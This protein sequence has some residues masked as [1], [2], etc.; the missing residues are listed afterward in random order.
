[1]AIR[2]PDVTL[3]ADIIGDGP[4]LLLLHGALGDRRTLAP[5]AAQLADRW[6]LVVPTQRHFGP[7]PRSVGIKR[8]GTASQAEDLVVMLD[9]LGLARAHVV[10]WSFS[11]HSTLAAALDA[12]ERI[13]SLFLY[14]PGFPTFVTD[15]AAQA[16]ISADG[17]RA[18]GPVAKAAQRGD[19][20]EAARDLIDAAAGTVGWF[21]AQPPEVRQIHLDNADTIG[22]LFSQ[23]PPVPIAAGDLARLVVPTTLA[24]GADTTAT[25]RLVSQAAAQ[26]IPGA[27]S[28][29]VPAAGHLLPEADPI[30]FARLIAAHLEGAEG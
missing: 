7:A 6:R 19:W 12:P 27:R 29:V 8:F 24:W 11:A 9:A 13:R 30:R 15:A 25:Y 22:L 18:F 26:A 5:V 23:T 1:M 2:L 28:I 3:A 14:E 17:A 16:E 20:A 10:A 21:D 4:P